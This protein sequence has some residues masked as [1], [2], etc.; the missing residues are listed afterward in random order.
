MSG[1]PL[2]R[3]NLDEAE[4][5][6]LQRQ[7]AREVVQEDRFGEIRTVAGVDLGFPRTPDGNELARAAVVVLRWPDLDLVE[8]RVVEQPVAFPYIP[9]LLSFREAPVGLAAIRSLEI[10]PDL[11]L[12]DGQGLAHP[13]RCGIAC[14]LGLL[15]DL[16]TVGCAKSIL[17][18]HAEEPGPNP[19]DWTPL[20][21]RGETIGAALRTRPKTKPIY[22]S[23]GHRISLAS[24]IELVSQCGRGYRLPEPTRLAD[25]IASRRGER[26]P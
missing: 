26:G 14:H 13:R 7:L 10:R 9:G 21:N 19:G 18:G 20:V 15:L 11:L 25:R 16:P 23:I 12:V 5:R 2:H 17:T 6:A 3:W 1:V 8:E 22:V 4:A 24:A